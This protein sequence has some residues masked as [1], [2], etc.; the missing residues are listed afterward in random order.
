MANIVCGYFNK[1]KY[2]F[3]LTLFLFTHQSEIIE[4][5]STLAF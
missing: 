4:V 2:D 3:Q 1:Q 5:L